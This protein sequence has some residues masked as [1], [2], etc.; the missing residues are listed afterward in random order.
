MLNP[1]TGLFTADDS[2]PGDDPPPIDDTTDPTDPLAP[3]SATSV[4][5]DG[6]PPPEA[7]DASGLQVR[8][9]EL[10]AEF[11]SA[12]SSVRAIQSTQEDMATSIEEMN[13]TVTQLV[14]IYDR[15]AAAENPFVDADGMNPTGTA[16]P[17]NSP[18]T[19]EATEPAAADDDRENGQDPAGDGSTEPASIV[20]FEDLADRPARERPSESPDGAGA[21]DPGAE[22]PATQDAAGRTETTQSAAAVPESA[23]LLRDL[24]GGYAG[25]VLVM[26]WLVSLM[27]GS[28]PAGAL[29]AINYY[30]DIDWISPA[31]HEHLVDVI[32]APELDVFVDPTRPRE[33]TATEH[34]VS[35]EYIQVLNRLHEL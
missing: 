7:T 16:P 4:E 14:G 12:E 18:P 35:H 15:L 2:A 3:P 30:E 34:A 13:E 24:P 22:T 10:E 27:E 32:A 29:R 28:G 21:R 20:G 33:P 5:D 6:D 9:E 23:P 31:V 19:D 17:D 11:D 25:D 8:V 26:E 1:L